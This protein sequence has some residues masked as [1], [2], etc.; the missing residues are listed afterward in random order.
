MSR[1]ATT[2]WARSLLA[3]VM[4][5]AA[6]TVHAESGASPRVERLEAPVMPI[7]GAAVPPAGFLALCARSPQD[8]VEDTD[9]MPDLAALEAAAYRNFW[10]DAFQSRSAPAAL[11]RPDFFDWAPVFAQAAAR[12][13]DKAPLVLAESLIVPAAN[14]ADAEPSVTSGAS[15]RASLVSD[16]RRAA[17]P[18]GNVPKAPLTDD[19]DPVIEGKAGLSAVAS[20][21]PAESASVTLADSKIEALS[22]SDAGTAAVEMAA[23]ELSGSALSASDLIIPGTADIRAAK[24]AVSGAA[25]ID[26]KVKEA[27]P[28][29]AVVFTLDRAGWRLVNGVNRRLNREIRP[30]SDA[31]LYGVEDFWNRPEGRGAQGDCEDY[32]LAKRAA[33]IAEGVPAAALSIAIVETRWGESHAVLL[34]ASDRGEFILDSLSQRVLR[35]DRVDYV[36][37]ERQLPGRP[38]DWVRVAV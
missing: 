17:D 33:L 27:E 36:W 5:A 1:K 19:I 32:V 37:R 38:F 7:A 18:S 13:A 25:V 31:R 29:M 23:M 35:W 24:K 22:A 16:L 15:E 12:R 10:S 6:G 3:A 28:E 2:Y 26:G 8:C 11:P 4:I 20:L 34:L 30:V 9:S 21:T 14:K